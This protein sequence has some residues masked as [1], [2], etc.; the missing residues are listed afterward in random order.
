[1]PISFISN[2]QTPI[3]TT[4][5][6]SS[7]VP[8]PTYAAGDLILMLVAA[9]TTANDVTV[10]GMTKQFFGISA[11]AFSITVLYKFAA[12]TEANY[13]VAS[14]SATVKQIITASY[15]GVHATTPF[16]TAQITATGSPSPTLPS[17]T[18]TVAGVYYTVAIGAN[19]T[20]ANVTSAT[21]NAPLIM[22]GK[23]HN[24][25]T[26]T[27]GQACLLADTALAAAGA[28]PTYTGTMP[29]SNWT[30][31]IFGLRPAATVSTTRYFQM[32]GGIWGP[33]A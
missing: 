30:Y 10:A 27:T 32:P 16:D 22:R 8:P 18:A 9:K 11:S 28:S 4:S 20:A 21:L 17:I 6:S 14:T 23:Y 26:T 12:A 33:V 25:G 13:T 19:F 5:T 1:M 3:A 24:G 7:S 29:S 2:S 31:S 15:R